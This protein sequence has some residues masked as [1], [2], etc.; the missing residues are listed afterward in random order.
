M[1]P[2]DWMLAILLVYS[3]V[4]AVLQGFFCA[5]FSL[6][7]IVV[8]FLLAC[9]YYRELG[10]HLSGLISSPPVAQLSAFLLL[11][12]GCMVLASLLGRMLHKAASAAGLGFLN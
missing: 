4:R 6:G 5:V 8:G 11:L 3:V 9:W 2:L 1:N 7:G 12:A 10:L